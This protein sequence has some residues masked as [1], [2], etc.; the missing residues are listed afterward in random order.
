MDDA[1]IEAINTLSMLKREWANRG[2]DLRTNYLDLDQTFGLAA[3]RAGTDDDGYSVL[4]EM[5]EK[6]K[7]TSP[8]LLAMNRLLEKWFAEVPNG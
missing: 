5:H 4:L 8:E 3:I 6:R 7:P 2:F 1:H